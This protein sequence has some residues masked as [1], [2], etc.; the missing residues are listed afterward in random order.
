MRNAKVHAAFLV[1][2]ALAEILSLGV[3]F[4]LVT[5]TVRLG[6][7]GAINTGTQVWATS[8]S[9]RDIQAAVDWVAAHGGIGTVYIPEGTYDFVDVGQSWTAVEVPAG[10]SI[11]GAPPQLDEYGQVIA[12]RTVLNM[13]YA[14]SG[15]PVWFRV[16]LLGEPA[17]YTQVHT[18]PF[19]FSNISM[20]GWRYYDTAS[21]ARSIGLYV[22][23]FLGFRVD[24]CNFQD[25]CWNAILI[26]MYQGTPSGQYATCTACGVVD[27]CRLVNS[28]GDPGAASYEAR[29]LDYGIGMRRWAC[30]LW[31]DNLANIWGQ[32][33][34][35]TIFIEDNYFSKWRHCVS[36][37]DGFHYVFR[38]NTIEG[39][40][41]YGSI[42]AHG[43]YADSGRPQAVGT[44]CIEVYNNVFKNPD[45]TWWTSCDAIRQRGGSGVIFNNTVIGYAELVE[46]SNDVGNF[47]PYSPKSH[48]NRTYIWNNALGGASAVTVTSDNTLNVHYFLRAPSQAQDGLTYTPY[49]YPFR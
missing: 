43:S 6:S 20:I 1:V 35:Y 18:E 22:Q 44:R 14:V 37:I 9:A 33:T 7:S 25:L 29:T 45:K 26:G 12:W 42:D 16:G 40:Y 11:A 21:T 15:T 4:S 39:D 27:H 23:N 3:A 49:P 48:V 30:R 2:V 19:R 8:G 24:H 13:P 36:A 32:Y 10:I 46:M 28:Y 5:L 17:C 41:G 38:Y 31:D 47:E 34:N